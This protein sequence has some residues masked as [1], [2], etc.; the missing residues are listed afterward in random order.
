MIPREE[1]RDKPTLS[2]LFFFSEYLSIL[3][4]EMEEIEIL[5]RRPMKISF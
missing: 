2:S 4:S 1:N 5:D 3:G